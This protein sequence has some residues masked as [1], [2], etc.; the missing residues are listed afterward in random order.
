MS[1]ARCTSYCSS[2]PYQGHIRWA[3]ISLLI[4]SYRPWSQAAQPVQNQPRLQSVWQTMRATKFCACYLQVMWSSGSAHPPSLRASGLGP[5]MVNPCLS[6]HM[7][8][9]RRYPSLKRS[10]R[11]ARAS[12]CTAHELLHA[13]G[14]SKSYPPSPALAAVGGNLSWA[15]CMSH[16]YSPVHEDEG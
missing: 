16:V 11:L 12:V 9:K 1:R 5:G 4:A 10:A 7:T 14:A 15:R 3:I 8:F 2:H 13:Q 6:V